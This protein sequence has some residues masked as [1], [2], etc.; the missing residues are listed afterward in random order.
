MKRLKKKKNF[1]QNL[2]DKFKKIQLPLDYKKKN[3]ILLLRMIL[4]KQQLRNMLK[5]LSKK[6]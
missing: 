6:S 4:M 1:N 5:I 2:F 3:Q